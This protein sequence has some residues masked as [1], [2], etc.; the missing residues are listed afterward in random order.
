MIR[1]IFILLSLAL[2]VTG[3]W[4][5]QE[6]EDVGFVVGVAVDYA[7]QEQSGD[8][9]SGEQNSK[10]QR[11]Y[12]I[13]FQFVTPTA[14]QQSAGKQSGGNLRG[15]FNMSTEGESILEATKFISGRTP[16][17]PSFE[18]MKAVL[19][20][21]DVARNEDFV[22]I[23]D[24]FIRYPEMPRNTNL[25]VVKG[26]AR[27]ALD[28]A[29]PDVKL[30]VFYLN[31]I[32]M[33]LK[34]NSR[35]I[36]EVQMG[37]IHE[38]ML[39]RRS[40][41]ALYVIPGQEDTRVEGNAIFSNQNNRMVGLLNGEEVEGHNLIT[42]S[43]FKG[44]IKARFQD[45]YVLFDIGHVSTSIQLLDHN[46]SNLKLSISIKADGSINEQFDVI[47][48]KN[49]HILSEL[50]SAV[51]DKLLQLAENVIRKCQEEFGV[52]VIGISDYL[53]RKHP[54]LWATLKNDWEKGEGYFRSTK[55][56]VKPYV[57]IKTVGLTN[58]SR[59]G[60]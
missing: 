44:P 40:F 17:A 15:Y 12:A 11:K 8:S 56:F 55:I 43:Y 34:N 19:V 7:K 36:L 53:S 6:I 28:A 57:A 48:F 39:S 4:D 29:P 42:G 49:P 59:D 9:S 25:F 50:E 32:I 16:R 41:S 20:S 38:R 51:E 2:F 31:R 18:H 10:E 27:K 58:K 30:P 37:D 3:C 33:N 22:K 52:D 54:R 45:T 1:R 35:L 5:R 13:T 60:S 46:P 24:F 14:I 23:I 26:E 21:E 47:D